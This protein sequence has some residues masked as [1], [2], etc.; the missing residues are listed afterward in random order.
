MDGEYCSFGLLE[1]MLQALMVLEYLE[2]SFYYMSM[3]V[4]NLRDG[5]SMAIGVGIFLKKH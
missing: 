2:E 5:C 1:E 3:V 4:N